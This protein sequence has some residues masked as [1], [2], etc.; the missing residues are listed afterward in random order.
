MCVKRVPKK[1]GGYTEDF[2]TA[3]ILENWRHTLQFIQTF[4][5][6]SYKT[7]MVFGVKMLYLKKCSLPGNTI[8]YIKKVK[9]INGLD[10]ANQ[11][12]VE[13]AKN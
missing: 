4:L 2:D 10:I 12:L 11:D 13:E 7:V 5:M 3:G 8:A 6:R 1:S 9:E